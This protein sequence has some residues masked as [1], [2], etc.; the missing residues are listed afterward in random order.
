M[1]PE[2]TRDQ[3]ERMKNLP[4]MSDAVTM[5][6]LRVVLRQSGRGAAATAAIALASADDQIAWQYAHLLRRNSPMVISLA[7]ALGI[8]DSELDNIFRAAAQIIL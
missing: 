5:A 6:Q 7:I 8:S 3:V 2:S 4:A 1:I